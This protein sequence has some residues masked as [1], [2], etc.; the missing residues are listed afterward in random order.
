MKIWGYVFWMAVIGLGI[1]A[2]WFRWNYLM[3]KP[4][5]KVDRKMIFGIVLTAALLVLVF[6]ILFLAG[7]GLL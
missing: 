5:K 2:F 7:K 1:L 6:I 4:K 3:E